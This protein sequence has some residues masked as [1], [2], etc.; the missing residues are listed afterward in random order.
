[1]ISVKVCRGSNIRCCWP[2][3][4]NPSCQVLILLEAGLTIAT[5]P[6]RFLLFL[7]LRTT[8]PTLSGYPYSNLGRVRGQERSG[9]SRQIMQCYSFVFCANFCSLEGLI[10]VLSLYHTE[11]SSV[12][13]TTFPV[14][15]STL[16]FCLGSSGRQQRSEEPNQMV[17]RQCHCTFEPLQLLSL[18]RQHTV[19]PVSIPY[20]SVAVHFLQLNAL[21]YRWDFREG[22]QAGFS[23]VK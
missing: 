10:S 1:V 22:G 3:P 2:C 6:H 18:H 20:L 21:F 12:S 17:R 15:L 16:L 9:G 8:L 13:Y 19:P 23:S 4:G 14:L 7:P 11:V 5:I